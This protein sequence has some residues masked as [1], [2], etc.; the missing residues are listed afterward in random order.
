MLKLK[1]CL[2]LDL[3]KI[4]LLKLLINFKL[5]LLRCTRK[6]AIE[7]KRREVIENLETDLKDNKEIS[8]LKPQPKKVPLRNNPRFKEKLR[9]QEPPEPI[10]REVIE[11]DKND[12]VSSLFISDIL[13]LYYFNRKYSYIRTIK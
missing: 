10:E 7:L 5:R 13:W 1:I 4:M 3:E 2:E 6:E 11:M 9:E 8:L 12:F